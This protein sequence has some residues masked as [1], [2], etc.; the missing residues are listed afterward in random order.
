MFGLHQFRMTSA[1]NIFIGENVF[2]MKKKK[3]SKKK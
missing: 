3:R 2:Q 1:K